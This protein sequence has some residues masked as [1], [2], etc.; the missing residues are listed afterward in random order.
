MPVYAFGSNEHHQVDRSAP[1]QAPRP[2]LLED[3]SHV[4]A[5]SWSQSIT[6]GADGTIK[7]RGLGLDEA[8]APLDETSVDIW[9]GQDEFVAALLKDGTLRRLSDGETTKGQYRS[10]SIN[11]RGEVLV[12]PVENDATL[13][14]YRDLGSL[15][16]TQDSH[17]TDAVKLSL[18]FYP[19]T[20]ASPEHVS[21][22]SSGAAH[23]LILASPSSRLFA[24]GDN[25]HGQLGVSQQR[26]T[27][28]RDDP[29]LH[30]VEFFDGLNISQV[31]TGA[32]HS[33]V[34][35]EAGQVYFFGSDQKGQ[36]G[37]TGGG[38]EPALDDTIEDPTEEEENESRG[39][40]EDSNEVVQV[41]AFGEST[42][43]KTRGGDL[44][45]GGSNHSGQLGIEGKSQETVA[46]FAKHPA[47]GSGN[48]DVDAQRLGK[49]E[50]V[51]CSRWTVYIEV[52]AP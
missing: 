33:I 48:R 18:P 41:C 2:F 34:L 8:S 21:T 19:S 30:R 7:V 31:A 3:S 35:T 23:F 40:S 27:S 1:L 32:F 5:A 49:A 44:W 13:L 51:V 11:S 16:G 4:V 10:A 45:V 52:D 42:M 47:F 38:S 15:F 46:P 12:A 24:L 28:S 6:R 22:I 50:N 25:R 9:L 36:C 37:G 26:M 29:L 43:L 14:L 39:D 17:E 20:A